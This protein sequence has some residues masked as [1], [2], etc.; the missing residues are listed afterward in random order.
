MSSPSVPPIVLT[1]A[2]SDPTGG[3]GVQAD[4]LTLAGLGCHPLSVITAITCQD[5]A[6]IEGILPIDSDWV[7]D[8]A[9][10]ILEDMPVAAFKLGF[11]GSV[12][13]IAAIAAIV[14]DYPDIPLVLDPVLA[15]GR[16]DDMSSEDMV[17]AI[18]ELLIP[19][20]TILT[21]NSQEAR[22]LAA[23]NEDDITGLALQTCATRLLD[24]GSE[25]VLITGT[26]ENTT[27]VIN[28]LYGEE[29][30][31]SAEEW[32][33]LPHTYHGSGC[34]LASALA[35]MLANNLDMIEAVYQ[36]QEYTW[37]TLS[38]GFR[39]GMGQHI[40]DRFFW[41]RKM[42]TETT[43]AREGEDNAKPADDGGTNRG[44]TE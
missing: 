18:N 1:F 20:T 3:A 9:R 14:S 29:G 12:D 6:G 19:Q 23:Q 33:R 24:Q 30:V 13:N 15:S 36:A 43:A 44:E 17:E 21:P 42:N 16:G 25:F 27:R 11:L 10:L 41:A 5:T 2:G 37:Q 34:T 22:R 40:P 8:Q 31:L 4:L 7:T 26:H 38:A 32:E 28:T 35:A 39:A